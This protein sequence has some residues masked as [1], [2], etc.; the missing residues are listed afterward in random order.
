MAGFPFTFAPFRLEACSLL[1]GAVPILGFGKGDVMKFTPKGDQFNSTIGADGKVIVFST[2]ETQV[3]LE[4]IVTS[5][6]GA[7][8]SL[9]NLQQAQ[10]ASTTILPLAFSFTDPSAGTTIN[11]T[12]IFLNTPE[13]AY[14][15][16]DQFN[17]VFKILLPTAMQLGHMI[18]GANN[19]VP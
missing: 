14:S 12:A 10:L 17:R 16:G 18:V 5:H 8:L 15:N 1:F 13:M 6:S 4:L 7:L 2:N 11:D 9:W 3:D 19:L